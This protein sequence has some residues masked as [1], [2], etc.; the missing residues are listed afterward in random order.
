MATRRET[1]ALYQ[2]IQI[3]DSAE[4]ELF[5]RPLTLEARR[6]LRIEVREESPSGT[7][8]KTIRIRMHGSDRRRSG[9]MEAALK[10][11]GDRLHIV[12]KMMP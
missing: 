2:E 7:S 3:H 12:A 4:G 8:K 10:Y 9:E 1:V 11:L 5:V 6:Y